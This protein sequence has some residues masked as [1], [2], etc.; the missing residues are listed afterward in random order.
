MFSTL[1]ED[2]RATL[3]RDPAARNAL[4]VILLYP[5]FHA[6]WMH[7]LAHWLW[8]IH[9]KLIAR[10]LSQFNRWLTGIEIH[11]AASIG[12][13]F[14]IDH[15]MG[16]VIG[17]TSEIGSCVTMFHNVTLGGVSSEKTKR[18]PTIGDHVV[19]G[20]GAQILGPIHIGAHSRVGADSVVV[21]VPGRV[22]GRNGTQSPDAGLED[23]HHD[24]LPDP[25]MERLQSLTERIDQL[26][27]TIQRLQ[28]SSEVTQ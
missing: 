7:R 13:G 6:I 23:L 2:I 27:E 8:R 1:R 16:T 17:E 5:G 9:F 25:T 15:G 19:I 18:H 3:E 20:A 4:E 10:G 24:R 14:F 21:G 12:P 26:E 28:S 22:R 11:P